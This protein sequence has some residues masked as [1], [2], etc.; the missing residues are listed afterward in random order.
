MRRVKLVSIVL[1]VFMISTL[2]SCSSEVPIEDDTE[3]FSTRS[4][5]SS[6]SRSQFTLETT[7]EQPSTDDIEQQ[8]IETF[9]LEDIFI[10]LSADSSHYIVSGVKDNTPIINIPSEYNSIPI[11]EIQVLGSSSL[12]SLVIPSSITTIH[13]SALADCTSLATIFYEGTQEDFSRISILK[14]NSLNEPPAPPVEVA[15]NEETQELPPIEEATEKTE[16]DV[17]TEDDTTIDAATLGIEIVYNT[18][19]PYANTDFYFVLSAD[20]TSLI[21]RAYTGTSS[22]VEIPSYFSALPV[23]AIESAAFSNNYSSITS[24]KIPATITD[25]EADTFNSFSSLQEAYYYGNSISIGSGN[26]PLTSILWYNTIETSRITIGKKSLSSAFTLLKYIGEES[27]IDLRD[28]TSV[29]SI[30]SIA[31][32]AFKGNATMQSIIIPKV[33]T[34]IKNNAFADCYALKRVWIEGDAIG[35]E[36]TGN[37][38][39]IGYIENIS[40]LD[41][42]ETDDNN[43]VVSGKTLLKYTG[44]NKN[45]TIPE[46][47]TRIATSAFF[48]ADID[49]VAIN[50]P[51]LTISSYAFYG[52]SLKSIQ[53][54]KSLKSIE[55]EKYAFAQCKNLQSANSDTTTETRNIFYLPS[56]LVKLGEGAFSGSDK[57]KEIYFE[58]VGWP[59][60]LLSLSELPS[61]CFANC[62]ALEKV[63][64]GTQISILKD[65]VFL[66]CD[67]LKEIKNLSA[68]SFKDS[69]NTGVRAKL[70]S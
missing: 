53:F 55:I 62:K 57:I 31:S 51:Q 19:Y 64:L 13:Y 26:K 63:Y 16:I 12:I 33:I 50:A 17:Q 40:S 35:I 36:K 32:F 21:L 60:P 25:I 27:E 49:T 69:T 48:G 14:E 45:I 47:I 28:F 66:G 29:Y 34:T 41:S 18:T 20:K 39:A 8:P 37:E 68:L 44:T 1:T 11:T 7:A 24:I 38:T 59:T 65:Y 67:N 10:Y 5:S 30:D 61:K 58:S 23:V 42:I 15:G 4:T 43:F 22:K 52:S 3:Q 46:S 6:T 70:K 56:T 9:V 54:S 2:F